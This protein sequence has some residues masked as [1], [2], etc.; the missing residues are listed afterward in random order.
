ML[1][2]R[3]SVRI[4]AN[5]LSPEMI[6]EMWS[7]YQKFYDHTRTSFLERLKKN[8]YYSIYRDGKKLIGFTGLRIKRERIKGRRNL[9]INFGQTIIEPK[10]RG[11]SLIPATG[12]KLCCK[13]GWEILL[14]KTYFWADCLTYKAYLV[15]AKTLEEYYP[16]YK[17][18]ASRQAQ[19]VIDC[20]GQTYYADSYC[21]TSGTVR[22]DSIVV[23]DVNNY[24][25]QEYLLDQDINFYTQH[26][27]GFT[28]GDGLITL[29]PVNWKNFILLL[30][31][32]GQKWLGLQ[33]RPTRTGKRIT[34]ATNSYR[35]IA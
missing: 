35:K 19:S 30:K 22:K 14:S 21:A 4:T 5:T 25:P 31:R 9:L 10:Y 18:D 27:P 29:G 8:D 13:F 23:N 20:I 33:Q 12:F 34:L 6:S 3:L 11:K 7:I 26:N 28:K 2:T 32:A 17:M 16:S 1:N 24:I 15:F